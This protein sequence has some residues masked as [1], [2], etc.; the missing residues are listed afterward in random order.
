MQSHSDNVSFIS[1]IWIC[2]TACNF[3]YFCV[4]CSLTEKKIF[5]ASSVIQSGTPGYKKDLVETEL[6]VMSLRMSGGWEPRFLYTKKLFLLSRH[7]GFD[8]VIYNGP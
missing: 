6:K 1:L 8:S 3:K 5:H 7:I 4:F 2:L